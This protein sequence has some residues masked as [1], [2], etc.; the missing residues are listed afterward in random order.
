[1]TLLFSQMYPLCCV[2]IRNFVNEI[3]NFQDDHLSRIGVIDQTALY[4]CLV[5][6]LFS[7]FF[8]FEMPWC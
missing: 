1:M 8:F 3:F 6:C 2:D 4:V 7:S 5:P